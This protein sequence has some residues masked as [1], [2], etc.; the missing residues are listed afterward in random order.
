METSIALEKI[1]VQYFQ[2][3][4]YRI[5]LIARFVVSLIQ[6]KSVLLS[7]IA[8]SLNPEYS[9]ATNYRRIQRFMA[10]YS[11]EKDAI[12]RFILEQLPKQE[13]LVLS[14]D[15]TNWKFG[16]V[17]INIMALGVAYRGIAFNLMWSLLDKRGNSNQTER[18]NFITL[19][20]R[21]V[22]TKTIKALVADREFIG[23]EWFSFLNHQKLKFHIR[24]RKNMLAEIETQSQHVFK[25]FVNQPINQPLTLYKP[26]LI[27]GQWLS[28]TGMKLKDGSY[29]IVVTNGNPKESLELYRQRW[30]IEEF[31]K[32]IKKTGFDF[33]ATHLVDLDRISTLLALVTIAFTWAHRMG[34]FLHDLV[35]PIPLKNHGYKVNSFFRHGLDHIRSILNHYH[36]RLDEFYQSLTVLTCR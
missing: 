31:F 9:K 7:E 22:P 11:F 28:V 21:L 12:V 16:S 18:I 15:R 36:R 29:I 19:L 33:E 13:D 20:V 23:V 30:G 2:S 27:C 34:E 10:N 5:D 35:K 32:A 6:V 25:L 1:L 4:C 24:I 26:Y 14:I 3:S 8:T 17:N